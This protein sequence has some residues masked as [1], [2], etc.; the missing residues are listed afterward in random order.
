L[1]CYC[2]LEKL[3][4]IRASVSFELTVKNQGWNFYFFVIV[5][6]RLGLANNRLTGAVPAQLGQLQALLVLQMKNNQMT[7]A[8]SRRSWVSC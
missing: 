3:E 7:G 2:R 8:P 5:L 4:A 1:W 6:R